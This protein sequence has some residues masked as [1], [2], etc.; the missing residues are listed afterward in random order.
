MASGKRSRTVPFRSRLA[1]A[2]SDWEA[3]ALLSG[4]DGVRVVLRDQGGAPNCE[5]FVSFQ[6]PPPLQPSQGREGRE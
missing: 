4:E 5:P 1:R 6:Y 3:L 2:D